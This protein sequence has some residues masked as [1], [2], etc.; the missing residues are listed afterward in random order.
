VKSGLITLSGEPAAAF[1]EG[2]PLTNGPIPS[3]AQAAAG[4]HNRIAAA[5]LDFRKIR[6]AFPFE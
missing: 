2:T 5:R 3:S 4:A 1:A 6:I